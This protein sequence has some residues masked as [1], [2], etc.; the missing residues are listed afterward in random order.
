MA[1]GEWYDVQ[2]G[3]WLSKIAV[4]HNFSDSGIIWNHPNNADLKRRRSPNILYP[5]DRLFL[6]APSEKQESCAT[7]ATHR[8]QLKS[9]R[10]TFDLQLLD[11]FRRPLKNQR[12]ILT[13]GKQRFQGS[14][15]GNGHLRHE[16]I[17]PVIN[18]PATL[19]FPKLGLTLSIRLGD[20]NPPHEQKSGE[21]DSYDDGLSGIQMRLANLG[22]EPGNTGGILDDDT[23]SAITA[24]QIFEMNRDADHA[25]GKLDPDTRNAIIARHKS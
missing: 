22:Y 17:D 10:D 24:F 6:P 8:F 23:A 19:R 11:G 15:D 2:Q 1:D 14:T 3:D 4:Q 7:D 12:Y 21:S 5:G 25:T 16:K 13:I 9:L 20:L 18:D